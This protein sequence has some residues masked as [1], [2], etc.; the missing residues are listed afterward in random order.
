MTTPA[1]LQSVEESLRV[2]GER[3]RI[4]L[5][6]LLADNQ[7]FFDITTTANQHLENI[8]DELPQIFTTYDKTTYVSFLP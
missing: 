5:D 2:S 3:Y 4:D 7:K 6:A 8:H 1:R